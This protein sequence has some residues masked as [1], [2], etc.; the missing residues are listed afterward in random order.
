MQQEGRSCKYKNAIGASYNVPNTNTVN[1]GQNGPNF[2]CNS[3][4]LMRLTTNFSSL[5]NQID[6]MK[7]A[8]TTDIQEGLEWG[9][10]TISPNSVFGDGSAYGTSDVSKI[11]ILMTDGTNDWLANPYSPNGSVYT[12]AGYFK[13]ADGTTAN[14]RLPPSNQNVN[15]QATGRAALDTLTATTC[16]NIKN[17]KIAIYT[18][19]FSVPQAQIDPAGINLLTNCATDSS[20]AFV[21]N[22]ATSLNTTFNKILQSI[23]AL[24]IS[25]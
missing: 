10:R 2:G 6:T 18:I 5:I 21:A 1:I 15:S 13:N 14:S 9:W 3:A 12:S 24:R 25:Q 23:G 8:G 17:A 11:V 16:T 20:H 22:D 19:G 4:A 7:S